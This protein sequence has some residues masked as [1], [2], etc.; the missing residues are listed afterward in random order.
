MADVEFKDFRIQVKGALG[1]LAEQAVEECC[2]ELESQ[3]KRNT[4]VGRVAGGQ[5][6]NNWGHHVS[7]NGDVTTGTVG[8]PLERSIWY[9]F[10]TG[11]Y[12][13]NNN[14][15]SGGWYIPIGGGEKEISEAVV[16]A[17]GFKVVEGKDGKKYAH[18]YGMKP[19]RPFWKAYSAL[20]NKLIK[21]IQDVFKGGMQ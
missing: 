9:E 18:T 4:V 20:K 17:Y 5:L 16:K 8:N 11:E 7:T 15:R 21:H 3:T 2:G 10:G 1:N 19:R 14:G 12:A 13:L 6:K